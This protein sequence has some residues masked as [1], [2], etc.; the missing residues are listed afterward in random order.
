MQGTMK[1]EPLTL[2]PAILMVSTRQSTFLVDASAPSKGRNLI[3]RAMLQILAL[4]TWTERKC[5]GE[6]RRHCPIYFTKV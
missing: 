6:R 2:P 4:K 1:F 3:F 5:G